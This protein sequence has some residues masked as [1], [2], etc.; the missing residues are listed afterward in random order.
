MES[1]RL[2]IAL[3]GLGGYSEEQLAPALL[4]T[5]YCYLSGIVT[6]SEKKKGKWKKKYKLPDENIYRYENFDSIKNN[7]AIDIVY[8]VLPNSMHA[9]YSIRAAKAGKHVICEKPMA[10]SVAE[11]DKMIEACKQAGV[12]LS[13]GYRL[14]FDPFNIEMMKLANEKRFGSVK[15]ISASH[16]LRNAQGWR[17]DK[18]LAGGGSLMDVGIYCINAGRYIT[19]LEPIAVEVLEEIKNDEEKFKSVEES[20]KWKMEYPDGIVAECSCSYSEYGNH[21]HVDAENG[22]F[23]LVPAFS[24]GGLKGKTSDSKID[25]KPVNQQAAQMDDFALAIMEKRPSPVS[26]E[27]GKLDLKIIEAVYRSMEMKKRI[28]L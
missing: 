3:V 18:V 26:G 7:N 22:W 15:K 14:H 10:M 11:C 17:L 6:G 9:E 13:I 27:M 8:I 23:E 28:E 24:Y 4:K 12:M 25:F 5:K 20:M 16:G 19:N 1:K 2:G 21:L